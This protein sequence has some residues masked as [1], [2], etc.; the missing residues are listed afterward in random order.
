M[1]V[2]ELELPSGKKGGWGKRASRGGEGRGRALYEKEA[3]GQRSEGSEGEG[4]GR[5]K[6]SF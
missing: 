3:S 1:E 2:G 6:N 5:S 4:A